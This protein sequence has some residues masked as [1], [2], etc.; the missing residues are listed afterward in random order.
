MKGSIPPQNYTCIT[1]H[2]IMYTANNFSFTI[3]T[4]SRA[5][6][7]KRTKIRHKV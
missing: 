7:P 2:F 6:I 1:Y 3:Q 4:A 5:F